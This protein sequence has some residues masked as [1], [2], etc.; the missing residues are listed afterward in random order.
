MDISELPDRLR[1]GGGL[2]LA[3]VDIPKLPD[4]LSVGEDLDLCKTLI[5]ELPNGLSVGGKIVIHPSQKDLRS[6]IKS[7][8]FAHKLKI[9]Y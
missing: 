3:G 2:Y 9:L 4:G 8:K 6:H 5:T 7:S 1:I